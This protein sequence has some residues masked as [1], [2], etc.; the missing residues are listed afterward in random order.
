MQPGVRH[1]GF[2]IPLTITQSQGGRF[3]RP[4]LGSCAQHLRT[5]RQVYLMGDDRPICMDAIK[6]IYAEKAHGLGG[7]HRPAEKPIE[8]V[9]ENSAFP[10]KFD[11]AFWERALG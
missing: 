7:Q 2:I 1:L 11:T 3:R 8:V 9:H 4:G 5:C 6:Q 10:D